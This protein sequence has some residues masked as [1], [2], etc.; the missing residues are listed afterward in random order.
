MKSISIFHAK[1]STSRNQYFNT[2][3]YYYYNFII[4]YYSCVRK[5]LHI[6]N[7][8]AWN[9]FVFV[10]K[11]N[12][13]WVFLLWKQNTK[14]LYRIFFHQSILWFLIKDKDKIM[15]N[16]H[17]AQKQSLQCVLLFYI[18][19]ILQEGWSIYSVRQI[20][21]TNS[22]NK[23]IL[24][25]I[26]YIKKLITI[27]NK[28]GRKSEMNFIKFNTHKNVFKILQRLQQGKSNFSKINIEV[29]FF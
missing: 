21:T 16:L 22:F 5:L 14:K 26:L 10:P 7:N 18:I 23:Q 19:Y 6:I 28:W 9:M 2:D 24:T 15:N 13:H 8:V 27:L 4:H 1:V 3:V 17:N 29:V 11:V 12:H 25:R 20:F